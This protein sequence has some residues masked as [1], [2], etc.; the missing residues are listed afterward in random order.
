MEQ[1]PAV[2]GRQIRDMLVVLVLVLLVLA[3]LVAAAV[4][5]VSARTE[6]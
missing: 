1:T 4:R 6:H 5:V 3:F 2:R